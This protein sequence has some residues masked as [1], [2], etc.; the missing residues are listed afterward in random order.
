MLMAQEPIRR[1]IPKMA[2]PTVLSMIIT[3]VYNMADTYFVHYLG[4]SATAAVGVNSSLDSIIMMAGSFLAIGANSYIARLLGSKEDEKASQVLSTAFFTAILTGL[5]V[6][7][8][9]LFFMSP[10][11][12][13]LG[14]TPTSKEYSIQYAQYVLM[15]APFMTSSFVMNQCLRS[16]GSA[17]FSMIGMCFGGILNIVLDP[18]FIFT[19]NMGVAGA[20][21]AT[22]ISKIISF[23]ILL[24]P[25]LRKNT[26]LHLSIKNVHY[27]KEIMSEIAK[28]GAPSSMRTL[29]T[30]IASIWMNNLAGN[31]SDS[32]LAAISVVNRIMMFPTFAIVG[33]GMGIQPV[34]GFNWG[35]KQYDRVKESYRF[36]CISGLSV[37]AVISGLM[38]IFSNTL[39]VLFSENDPE[40]VKL[41]TYCLRTQSAVML[42]QGWVVIIN[43]MYAGLGKAGGATLLSIARQGICFIPLLVI[44]PHFFGVYGLASVQAGADVLTLFLAVPLIIKLQKELTRI[45]SSS[46][47]DSI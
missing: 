38:F 18:I 34:V 6:M 29:L 31:F 16:E 28:I 41:G 23:F 46:G 10:L 42:I 4:T 22:A 37:M 25:Y 40:L 13:L 12:D 9:G 44:L 20:A 35:S 30:I 33:F 11:V 32:A 43:S 24:V 36:S 39:I 5:T 3:S 15:A 45:I 2:L 1:L 14:A 27:S 26:I 19:F 47:S 7:I 21:L 8:F 17:V